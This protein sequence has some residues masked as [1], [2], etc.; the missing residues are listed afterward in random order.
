MPCGVALSRKEHVEKVEQHI[1]YLNTVDTTIMGS[2]NGQA[3]LYLWYSLRKKGIPGI[4]RDVMYVV[5]MFLCFTFSL[6]DA[7]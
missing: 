4:K 5:W 2:R 6:D 1:E 7:N 3:A